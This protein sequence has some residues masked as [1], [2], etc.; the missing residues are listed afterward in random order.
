[1]IRALKIVYAG[2]EFLIYEVH[3]LPDIFRRMIYM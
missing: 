3:K 2:S 1:M